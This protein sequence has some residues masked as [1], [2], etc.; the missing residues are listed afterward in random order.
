MYIGSTGPRGPAPPG[1]RGRRQLRRRG[2]R[3]LLPTAHRHDPAR[4]LGHSRRRRARH[5]GGH[6]G[7]VQQAG[8][9]GR[10]HHAA[11]RR[12][13]RRRSGYKVSGGL[14]GV[15][16]S[17]VNALSE[18]LEL[19]IYRD[20]YHWHQRYERGVPV[21]P[22]EKQAKLDKRRAT[23]TTVSF[24]PDPDVFEDGRLRLPRARA[25]PARDGLPD[26]GP[27]HRARRRARRG[28][29]RR[30]PVRRRH[31]AT[32]STTSTATR[33]PSTARSS[34]STNE[35]SDGAGRG[36]HAVELLLQRVDLHLRQQHQHHRGRRAP[37]G[38]PRRAHAHH[39]RLRPPEGP[40]QGERGEPH[41]RGRPR[42]P[43]GGRLGQAHRTRSS[44]ARPRPSSATPRSRTLRR[45]DRQ[46]QARRVP[47][48]APARGAR[49]SS[50]RSVNAARAR[51]AARK[52]RDLTRRK[53]SSRAR[54]LPGKLAD[55]S[56]R[57]PHLSELY[58][59]EGDSAGGSAKQAPRPQLPGH[60]AA[61]RQDHQRRE[62]AHRQDARR[63]TRS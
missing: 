17:V 48:G 15:G 3:R 14:H 43:D 5:P 12:Q 9:R 34:T 33:T 50:R 30:L 8:R 40:A 29:D 24:M 39:Q 28:R 60:P 52:A 25:A 13:V 56:I 45:D 2:A 58:L 11:R 47:R 21:T 62:G 44:R 35:T 37:V 54:T 55:C 1:L 63:T 27:A 19:E 57:D 10:A 49:R 32:S 38:L 61:A 36:R 4:Q 41:R 53:G 7:E 20:G 31:R 23:G 6:H 26:Q 18:W 16:V 22:L 42:G 46:R 59:V 51:D